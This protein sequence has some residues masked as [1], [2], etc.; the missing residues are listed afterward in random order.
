MKQHLIYCGLMAN[1]GLTEDET[2]QLVNDLAMK[3]FP[4]GHTIHEAV[5]RWAGVMVQCNEATM[6]VE[7]WE[8]NGFDVPPLAKFIGDYKNGAAQESVVLITREVEAVVF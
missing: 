3:H 2:R 8:M 7:V 6:I 1:N 4:N 5:G